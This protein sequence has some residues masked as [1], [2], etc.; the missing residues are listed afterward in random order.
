MNNSNQDSSEMTPSYPENSVI[1]VFEDPD[2][3]S[4]VVDALADRPETAGTIDVISDTVAEER[5]TALR[6][7]NPLKARI[8]RFLLVASNEAEILDRYKRSIDEGRYVVRV[9]IQEGQENAV[10]EVM[11]RHGGHFVNYFGRLA[12]TTLVP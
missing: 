6:D 11:Q 4:A 3:T 2:T 9:P 7:E 8:I 10:A 5:I 12:I 1:G